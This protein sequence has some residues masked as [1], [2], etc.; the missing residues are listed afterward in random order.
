ML[1][2][3][4]VSIFDILYIIYKITFTF[5]LFRILL[6]MQVCTLHTQ[7]PSKLKKLLKL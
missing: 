5:D 2:I 6:S 3:A 4:F 7:C 1:Y